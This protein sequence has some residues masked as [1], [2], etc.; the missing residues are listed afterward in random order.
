[1]LPPKYTSDP[2]FPVCKQICPTWQIETANYVDVMCLQTCSYGLSQWAATDASMQQLG[3]M[4]QQANAA[5]SA[6]QGGPN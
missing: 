6:G 5:N 4:L 3:Q 2:L 1:M